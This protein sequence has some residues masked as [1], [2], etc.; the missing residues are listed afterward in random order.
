MTSDIK[1]KKVGNWEYII[2]KDESNGMKVSIRIFADE[3]LL[4]AKKDYLPIR[5]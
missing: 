1:P 3:K 4:R 5:D 2:E